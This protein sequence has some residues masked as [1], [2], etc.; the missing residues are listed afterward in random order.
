MFF[1]QNR[2]TGGLVIRELNKKDLKD[3]AE[4]RN[5]SINESDYMLFEPGEITEDKHSAKQYLGDDT[6]TILAFLDGELIGYTFLKIPQYKKS[7]HCAYLVI[8]IKKEF[9]GRGI[10]T[11]LMRKAEDLAREMGIMRIEL[12]VMA[13]NPAKNLYERM[14]YIVEGRKIGVIFQND[15]Y[16]DVLAMA[17]HLR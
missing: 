11:E 14:G 9:R 5:S 16:L 12:E 6:K 8:A 15:R 7:K 3:F 10:G 17:K 2:P 13:E 1:S 4:L